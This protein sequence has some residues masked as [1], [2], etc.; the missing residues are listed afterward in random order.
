MK[1][2]LAP[3]GLLNFRYAD[4]TFFL[5]FTGIGCVDVSFTE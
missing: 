1:Q 4:V 5:L 3:F 2:L